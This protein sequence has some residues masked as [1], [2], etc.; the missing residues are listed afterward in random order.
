MPNMNARDESNQTLRPFILLLSQS[1]TVRL[2]AAFHPDGIDAEI[3]IIE[4]RGRG[5]SEIDS[6]G[7]TPIMR[8]LP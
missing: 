8:W 3:G 2:P 6:H 4:L 7:A 1:D 5:P